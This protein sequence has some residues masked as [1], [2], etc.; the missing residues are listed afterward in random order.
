MNAISYPLSHA[1]LV[2]S[3]EPICNDSAENNIINIRIGEKMESFNK[4]DGIE[5]VLDSM[6]KDSWIDSLDDRKSTELY[7]LLDSLAENSLTESMMT[8]QQK[9]ECSL[10]LDYQATFR[11]ENNGQSGVKMHYEVIHSQ[12]G[13]NL[14]KLNCEFPFD[15]QCQLT[16]GKKYISITF[17]PQCDPKLENA[18]DHRTVMER[19]L[20]WL[21]NLFHLNSS[22]LEN[23]PS[24]ADMEKDIE[25]SFLKQED[26]ILE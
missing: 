16:N 11:F 1:V 21:R 20:D 14:F 15:R 8:L 24:D 18:L 5:H 23:N 4:S 26:N 9:I 19:L 2:N 22:V 10:P 6:S 7:K 13:C 17:F 12:D 25:V 3:F